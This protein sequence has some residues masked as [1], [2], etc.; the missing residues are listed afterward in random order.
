MKAGGV[1]VFSLN[2]QR[3]NS[4]EVLPLLAS[5]M[6]SADLANEPVVILTHVPLGPEACYGCSANNG[7]GGQLWNPT[8]QKQFMTAVTT[9]PHAGV[10]K[11]IFSGHVHDDEFRVLSTFDGV[12]RVPHLVNWIMPSLPPYNPST[13]PA[14]RSFQYRG[15][16]AAD[17]RVTNYQQHTF[18]L[19]SSNEAGSERWRVDDAL[20]SFGMSDL[21]V[22]SYVDLVRRLDEDDDLFQAYYQAFASHPAIKT[23]CTD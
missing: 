5:T 4:N 8:F 17:W 7:F 9:G 1:Q 10:V 15:S 21:S 22:E 18:L 11:G 13:N 6:E 19:D 16:T 3:L 23:S 14:V 20:T 2:T 12:S